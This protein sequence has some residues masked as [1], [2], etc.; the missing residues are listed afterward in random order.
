M[1]LKKLLIST[2]IVVIAYTRCTDA[3]RRIKSQ[4]TAPLK[5]NKIIAHHN[6]SGQHKSGSSV[7]SYPKQQASNPNPGKVANSP[8]AISRQPNQPIAKP[9]ISN[10]PVYIVNSQQQN[11]HSSGNDNFIAGYVA[12]SAAA[13]RKRRRKTTTIAPSTTK[14]PCLNDAPMPNNNLPQQQNNSEALS[15]PCDAISLSAESPTILNIN[16]DNTQAPGNAVTP[17]IRRK[18]RRKTT[19]VVPITE[20]PMPDINQPQQQ[21]PGDN[22]ETFSISTAS[23]GNTNVNANNILFK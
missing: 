16:A 18:R 13:H 1:N 14:T 22:V 5:N 12:G 11:T 10:Q 20:E 15:L 21:N 8:A 2:L 23:P 9:R 4:R 7:N 6:E 17:A 3:R 19:T